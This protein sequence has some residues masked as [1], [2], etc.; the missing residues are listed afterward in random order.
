VQKTQQGSD[1]N[2]NRSINFGEMTGSV[3][4]GTH[5]TEMEMTEDQSFRLNVEHTYNK[6]Q[7]TNDHRSQRGL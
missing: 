6:S 5:D 7:M 1:A 4:M 3:M 2:D